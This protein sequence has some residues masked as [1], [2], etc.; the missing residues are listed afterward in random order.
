MSLLDELESVDSQTA[1]TVA[2]M[3][4]ENACNEPA[5]YQQ[6]YDYVNATPQFTHLLVICLEERNWNYARREPDPLKYILTVIS[7]TADAYFL[8]H[9]DPNVVMLDRHGFTLMRD[10]SNVEQFY[11]EPPY[12]MG[13]P[14]LKPSYGNGNMRI[15]IA[16]EMPERYAIT[17]YLDFLISVRTLFGKDDLAPRDG[18]F[19]EVYHRERNNVWRTVKPDVFDQQMTQHFGM[20][21]MFGEA[22][23]AYFYKFVTNRKY[24]VM[25][26][27][28]TAGPMTFQNEPSELPERSQYEIFAMIFKRRLMSKLIDAG[29]SVS[30]QID[31]WMKRADCFF[32]KHRQDDP[33]VNIEE[34]KPQRTMIYNGPASG[35][36]PMTYVFKKQSE[37][38]KK[39]PDVRLT[40]IWTSMTATGLFILLMCLYH[41]LLR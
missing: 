22:N 16:V 14:V 26:S 8:S 4:E 23:A 18:E 12:D 24:L 17:K 15:K 6:W 1:Q 36:G 20:I 39:R 33:Y 41:F 21:P 27:E 25:S 38:E 7:Q 32:R 31:A 11:M 37:E 2:E 10:Y 19:V 9:S 29:P 35:P 40:L 3:S 13:G 30:G 34:L 5:P 28:R